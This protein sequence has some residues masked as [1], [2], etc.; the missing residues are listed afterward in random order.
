ML[1][2]RRDR[3]DMDAGTAVSLAAENKGKRDELVKVHPAVIEH[4][5][6]LAGFTPTLFPWN[7]DRRT[8][9]VQFNRIQIAAGIRLPCSEEHEHT[10][11]C[12]AARPPR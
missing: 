11:A 4:L 10:A 7:H 8:L 12:C 6:R 2:I 1:S 5:R 9:Y 3:L